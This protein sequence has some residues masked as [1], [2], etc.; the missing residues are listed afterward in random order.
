MSMITK[1]NCDEY[2]LPLGFSALA[3]SAACKILC[4]EETPWTTKA[5]LSTIAIIATFT[6]RYFIPD[7]SGEYRCSERYPSNNL[8]F[9]TAFDHTFNRLLKESKIPRL[10]K[11][12]EDKCRDIWYAKSLEGIC[13]G[14]TAVFFHKLHIN[15]S[16]S[17]VEIARSFDHELAPIKDAIYYQL[18]SNWTISKKDEPIDYS[19]AIAWKEK[20][21]VYYSIEDEESW[22]DC[23]PQYKNADSLIGRV[24][25]K[26][27]HTVGHT[28]PFW[29]LNGLFGYFQSGNVYQF[30]N[31]DKFGK[32]VRT[33]ILEHRRNH[34]IYYPTDI[35]IDIHS[36]VTICTKPKTIA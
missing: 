19:F 10:A 9:K 6:L 22:I 12:D 21:R 31:R 3:A 27:S 5:L 7:Y 23:F 11:I 25:Y 32:A 20:I 30:K 16:E 34:Q 8:K 18:L 15:P 2:A 35:A 4:D 13:F 26:V 36:P 17:P 1:V 33:E 24:S 29:R 28:F 14:I